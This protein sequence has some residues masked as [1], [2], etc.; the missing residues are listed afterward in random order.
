[1]QASVVAKPERMI[2]TSHAP[3]VAIS[4]LLAMVRYGGVLRVPPLFFA[5]W[6]ADPYRVMRC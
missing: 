2:S 4:L 1:M 6:P 3:L 5:I